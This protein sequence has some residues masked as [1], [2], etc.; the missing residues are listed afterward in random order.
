MATGVIATTATNYPQTG[1][2]RTWGQFITDVA[3]RVGGENDPGRYGTI[4]ACCEAAVRGY[5]VVL[6]KFNQTTEDLTLVAAT[7]SYALNVYHAAPV[8]AYMLDGTSRN[9]N[10]EVQWVDYARWIDVDLVDSRSAGDPPLYYTSLNHHKLGTVIF[11]PVPSLPATS[12][13]PTVRVVYLTRVE[14]P[15]TDETKLNVPVEV[16]HGI[17]RLAIAEALETVRGT[18][19]GARAMGEAVFIKTELEQRYRAFP[20]Y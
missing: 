12:G 18:G 6:W 11:R 2:G 10:Q 4:R 20:A 9:T 8:R 5:N 7:D 1:S 19:Q 3:R 16:E 17:E 14:I 13:Y 15:G